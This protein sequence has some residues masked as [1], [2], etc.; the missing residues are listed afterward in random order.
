MD[1]NFNRPSLA[2]KS[3]KEAL[4]ILDTWIADTS[5]KLNYLVEQINKEKEK[6]NGR[7]NN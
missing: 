7:T 5:D 2:G 1:I 3:E 4:A 6:S